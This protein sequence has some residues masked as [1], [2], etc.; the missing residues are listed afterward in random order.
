MVGEESSL[1][2]TPESS[3]FSEIEFHTK[4]RNIP[5]EL[6]KFEGEFAISPKRFRRNSCVKGC[7]VALKRVRDR[8]G[9]SLFY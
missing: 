3:A 4:N 1:G 5:K 8:A 9:D 2:I 7:G 6:A